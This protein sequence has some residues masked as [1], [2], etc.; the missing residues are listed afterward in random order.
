MAITT[1]AG[2]GEYRYY[3]LLDNQRATNYSYLSKITFEE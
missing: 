3:T 1:A 2:I